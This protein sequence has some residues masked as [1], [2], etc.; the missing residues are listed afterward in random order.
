MN[1]ARAS[2][3]SQRSARTFV[4]LLESPE[5]VINS[6]PVVIPELFPTGNSGDIPIS[7]Q[8]L[9]YGGKE[10]GVGNFAKPLDEDHE[11]LS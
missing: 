11:L 5:D 10:A 2:T 8:E 7:V 6:I 3:S 9:V 1:A 4:T